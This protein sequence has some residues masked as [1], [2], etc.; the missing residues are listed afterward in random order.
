MGGDH[1]WS[2]GDRLYQHGWSGR[3]GYSPDHLRRDSSSTAAYQRKTI[4]TS[5][6][7]DVLVM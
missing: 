2:G 6:P 4:K 7:I 5:D 3:T 1:G